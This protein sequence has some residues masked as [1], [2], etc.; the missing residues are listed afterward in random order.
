MLPRRRSFAHVPVGAVAAGGLALLLAGCAAAP[1]RRAAS[2]PSKQ[3]QYGIR[4]DA[5]R[6]DH[7]SVAEH[8][9]AEPPPPAEGVQPARATP[10]TIQRVIRASYARLRGCY[11]KGLAHNRGL[12]GTV[13]VSFIIN[14]DGTVRDA[15]DD[16]STLPDPHVVQCVVEG[17]NRLTYPAL[18]GGYLTVVY[19][20]VFSP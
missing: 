13:T 2:G 16:A 8:A 14:T 3:D 12:V 9:A 6:F 17:F 1:P 10:D 20:I 18:D 19:P 11:E 15:R 4:F 7:G 5:D